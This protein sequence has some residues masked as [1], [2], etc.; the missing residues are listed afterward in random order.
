MSPEEKARLIE[1]LKQ[2]LLELPMTASYQ[3]RKELTTI[4]VTLMQSMDAT[5]KISDELEVLKSEK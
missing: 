3:Y 4:I 5:A 1:K 2:E